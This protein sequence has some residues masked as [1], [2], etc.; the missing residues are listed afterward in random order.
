MYYINFINMV[1]Y[2][3]LYVT[4]IFNDEIF[5]LRS[6]VYNVASSILGVNKWRCCGSL[7]KKKQTISTYHPKRRLTFVKQRDNR[8]L[9]ELKSF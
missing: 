4:S 7:Q 1:R 2:Q 3:Y 8:N 6:E 5:Y 9:L